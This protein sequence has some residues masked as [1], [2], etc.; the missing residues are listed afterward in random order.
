M[1]ECAL[2]RQTLQGMDRSTMRRT[3]QDT[4]VESAFLSG[5]LSIPTC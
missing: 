4:L 3:A 5:Q 1:E 2:K